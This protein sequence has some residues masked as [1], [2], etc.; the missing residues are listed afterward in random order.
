V[1][2]EAGGHTFQF[3]READLVIVSPGIAQD[4]EVIRKLQ[5]IGVRVAGELAVAA[6]QLRMPV[7]AITGTNGKT[8]VTSLIGEIVRESGRKVFV[9]GNIGTPIFEFLRGGSE[10]EIMVLEVS[11]FQLEMAGDF[12]PDVG[13]L[14]NI[15]P[16]H[17]DRHGSL[18]AYASAKMELFRHQRPEQTAVLCGDDPEC[19]S[20]AARITARCLTFGSGDECAARIIGRTVK[21]AGGDGELEYDLGATALGDAI[22]LSNA[23]AAILAAGALGIE[24]EAISRALKKFRPGPHRLQ[25]VAEFA[26]VRYVNDSK[27]TNTGAVIAALRQIAGKAVLIAG[28]RDK[29]EDYRLLRERV[30]QKARAVIV[31]GEAGAM[32]KAALEDCVSVFTAVTLEDAVR[33]G[34]D[35]A[36]PG[37]TVLLSPACASFDMFRSYGHRGEMFAAAVDTLMTE[38]RNT[39]EAVQ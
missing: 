15:T 12:T 9:G 38:Q 28:G 33:L 3:L 25:L 26:G 1:A 24:P 30:Q 7:V 32:I 39:A 6:S 5:A 17:I 2:W 10:A 27:A 31:I 35:L 4:H 18:D 21:V 16:D 34:R 22:G 13:V 11:S 29:G 36:Q 20:R 19:L 14:L 8:T 37:D 23:A